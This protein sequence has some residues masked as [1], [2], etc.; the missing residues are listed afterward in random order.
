MKKNLWI[1]VLLVAAFA[2]VATTGC[3]NAL[4]VEE[5]TETYE[6]YVLDKGFNA[7]AGQVYQSGWAIGGLVFQGK[8][9]AL[10][11]AKDLGYDVEMFQKARYLE[12]EMPDET[13][14]RSGVDI[15][16][17]GEDATG[18]ATGGGGMWNQQPIAGG[19]G[20]V[21]PTF[22]KKDGNK[23]RI[24]LTKAL[25]NYSTYRAST[26]TK[27]KIIM[28]VNAPSYG[29]VEGLVKKATL[30][31]PNTPP[32]SVGVGAVFLL[33][34]AKNATNKDITEM[35][36]TNDFNLEAEIVPTNATNQMIN[37]AIEGWTSE[38]GLTKIDLTQYKF[39]ISD[40]INYNADGSV[41]DDSELGKY[42]KAKKELFE[43]INWKQ[44][45][46]ITDD[47][48]YPN[49]MGF[50]NVL[51]VLSVPFCN[52]PF[53]TNYNTG[54]LSLGEVRLTAIIKN[55]KLA[56]G[57]FSE[58]KKNGLVLFIKDPP[59]FVF[60]VGGVNQETIWYGAVDNKG[61]GASGGKMVVTPTTG[62]PPKG[63]SFTSTFGP[64]GGYA[65]SK[66]Y[67]EVKLGAG[68]KLSNYNK[69]TLRY[70][71]EDTTKK[72]GGDLAGKS[73]R[74][75]ASK[76]KPTSTGA[77]TGAVGAPDAYDFG[78]YIST[79]SFP[80][81]YANGWNTDIT[82]NLFK[83]EA[84]DSDG[85]KKNGIY[86]KGTTNAA[87]ERVPADLRLPATNQRNSDEYELIKDAETVYVWVL[88]W[89]GGRTTF[90]ISNL[91]FHLAP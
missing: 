6:E 74:L 68:K 83:D 15:I 3:V 41:K 51:G 55:G 65:N 7:W 24:D 60:K 48:V 2:L 18:S 5:D 50:R 32:P 89:N 75:R 66:H 19:S 81:S 23:L 88:P 44:E 70:K 30:L 76:E 82:F 8:G 84:L 46:Y 85:D 36:W 45:A 91:E 56:G 47:S 64:G 12:I 52:D 21:D 77:G 79:T 13:Y 40:L 61:G 78:A 59:F 58:Y 49:T 27:V 73:I 37:W 34:N 20:D 39:D 86:N 87:G 57:I 62:V 4:K 80:G 72:D 29:N 17:G 22:A 42:N 38:D 26:T 71:G 54:K 90:S 31:I 10:T 28:Q 25:K 9:D 1:A 16:W 11:V 53:N 43:K 69:V 67:I 35:Y 63:T 33:A 14:P